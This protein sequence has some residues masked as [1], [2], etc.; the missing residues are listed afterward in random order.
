[1]ETSFFPV[2]QAQ[3]KSNSYSLPFASLSFPYFHHGL[4]SVHPNSLSEMMGS[5]GGHHQVHFT[6]QPVSWARK[7]R[8]TMNEGKCKT[9]FVLQEQPVTS[10]CKE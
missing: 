10:I 6:L 8:Y 2:S 7:M 4:Y 3:L 5:P 9:E 1:M